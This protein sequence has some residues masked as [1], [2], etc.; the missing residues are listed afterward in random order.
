MK[1]HI[2]DVAIANNNHATMKIKSSTKTELAL[3]YN[4]SLITLNKWIKEIDGLNLD[5]K[6]R[7]LTPKQVE[8]IFNHL[9]EP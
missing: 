9:G 7:I 3:S 1:R 6:K 5:P 4:I 8:I 2:Y